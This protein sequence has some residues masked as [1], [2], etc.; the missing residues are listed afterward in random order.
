[1]TLKQYRKINLV[2]YD[3]GLSKKY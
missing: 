3:I 2:P 1:M